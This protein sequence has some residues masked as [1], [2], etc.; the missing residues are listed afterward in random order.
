MVPCEGLVPP[1]AV[2]VVARPGNVNVEPF[3]VTRGMLFEQGLY[4]IIDVAQ[5]LA[6]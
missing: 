3:R 5:S 2:Y 4:A 1:L 6:P